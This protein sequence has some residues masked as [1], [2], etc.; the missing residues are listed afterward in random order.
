MQ[1]KITYNPIGVIHS[2]HKTI[3]NIPIQPVGAKGIKGEIEIYPEFK[4]G[5]KD[6][7]GF[8][9]IYLLYHFH[10]AEGY[11]L[12]VKP[13]L[14][15]ELHGVFATRAP[16]RP[17]GIGL[18]VLKLNG[19][20]N[21]KVFVENVDI[22]DGTPILDIKPYSSKFNAVENEKIGWLEKNINKSD[23]KKSDL[24]FK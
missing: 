17:N 22:L 1:Q 19:I 21:N 11:S 24:R 14:D 6:L 15:D 3:E 23:D 9:H 12:Q 13:F 7:E 20:E 16:K 4:D 5:L 8:S 18:S 10:K 2:P